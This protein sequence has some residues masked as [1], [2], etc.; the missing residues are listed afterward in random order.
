M[1]KPAKVGTEQPRDLAQD[2][3]ELKDL[4]LRL[5]P[6]MAT[7][8]GV[9]LAGVSLF[10]AL[11]RL[12]AAQTNLD[13]ILAFCAVVLLMCYPVSI[14]AVRTRQMSRAFFLARATLALFFLALTLLLYVGFRVLIGTW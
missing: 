6:P 3:A 9:S 4:I 5:L 8:A 13:E 14:W 10:Q 1:T 11:D 12:N 2:W 7:L